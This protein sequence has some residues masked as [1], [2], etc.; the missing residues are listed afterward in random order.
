M[1]GPAV[2][3]REGRQA[4]ERG[5]RKPWVYL[6]LVGRGPFLLKWWTEIQVPTERRVPRS[7]KEVLEQGIPCSR[8]FSLRLRMRSGE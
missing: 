6:S 3:E 7:V 1:G 2:C 5:P 8:T 4:W